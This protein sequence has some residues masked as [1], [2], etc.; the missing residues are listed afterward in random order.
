MD[1]TPLRDGF[2]AYHP[3]QSRWFEVLTPDGTAVGVVVRHALRYHAAIY[4]RGDVGWFDDERLASDA[5]I[6]ALAL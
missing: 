6:A 2:T 4:R 5:I 3:A 1:M